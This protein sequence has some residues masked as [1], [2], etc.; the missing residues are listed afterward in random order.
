[1][2][3]EEGHVTAQYNMGLYYLSGQ[4]VQKDIPRA[5][6]W[7][8]KAAENGHEKARQLLKRIR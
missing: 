3:A 6:Q 2:A 8:T 7:L 4:G 1:M 5:K